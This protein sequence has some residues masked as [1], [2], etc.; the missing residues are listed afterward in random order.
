MLMGYPQPQR[1]GDTR[2]RE[3]EIFNAKGA[4]RAKEK[5]LIKGKETVSFF[6]L[7]APLVF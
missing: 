1:H 2:Q 3:K 6:V 5:N 4:K 7:S